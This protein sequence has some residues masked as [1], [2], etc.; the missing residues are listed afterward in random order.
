[1]KLELFCR[2]FPLFGTSSYFDNLALIEPVEACFLDSRDMDKQIISA[3]L[4]LDKP[5]AFLP[6]NHFMVSSATV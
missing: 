5:I 4:R 3:V 1:L 2:C 6:L